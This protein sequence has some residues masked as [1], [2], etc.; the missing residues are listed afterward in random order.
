MN[1]WNRICVVP[2]LYKVFSEFARVGDGQPPAAC[3]P[4][5]QDPWFNQLPTRGKNTQSSNVLIKRVNQHLCGWNRTWSRSL[6]RAAPSASGLYRSSGP[7]RTAALSPR[8]SRPPLESPCL[9]AL[10][11]LW[12]CNPKQKPGQKLLRQIQAETSAV[13]LLH[14]VCSVKSLKNPSVMF[15]R[16]NLNFVA[17][18]NCTSSL[19]TMVLSG[20]RL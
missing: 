8:T 11:A 4:H 13:P 17:Q 10:P 2:T 20:W 12:P 6:W 15:R 7:C 9:P 1:I 16:V 5:R 18:N 14:E 19:S 3:V